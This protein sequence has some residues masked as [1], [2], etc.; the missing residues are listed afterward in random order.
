MAKERMIAGLDLGT[1]KVCAIIGEITANGEVKIVG[2]GTAASYGIRRGMVVNI[3]QTAA[4]IRKAIGDA[5]RMAGVKVG[6]VHTGIAGDHIRGLNSRGVVAVSDPDRGITGED[7][8]R[9]FD[10]AKAVAIPKDRSIIHLLPQGFIVDDQPGIKEP[11]GISGIRLEANVYIVTG[12]VTAAQN[13][14]KSV[15]Q[16]GRRIKELV[17]QPLASSYAVCSPDE[18]EL[19]VAVIDIGGGTTDIALFFEGALRYTA[20]VGLG[21]TNVSKDIAIGLSTPLDRAEQIKKEHG[22]ALLSMVDEKEKI[23]VPMVGGRAP[24]EVPK[25]FLA[26]IIQPRME[27]IFS[28]ALREIQQSDYAELLPAGII[29]TGGGAM[30]EGSAQLAEQVFGMPTKIG[31]PQGVTGIT[32]AIQTPIYST[33]VGL[34]RYPVTRADQKIQK[35]RHQLGSS[36]TFDRV[37]QWFKDFF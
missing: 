36:G 27:E 22:C 15:N 23:Q 24:R 29:L 9:V 17:L 11:I 35:D 4:A 28:F 14:Y 25:S 21:G 26:S 34:L 10:A 13:I 33:A 2:M 18:V 32:D 19:G 20:V 30:L 1:T 5:E 12:A 16:A 3:D 6:S 31:I 8:R 37:K 7:V